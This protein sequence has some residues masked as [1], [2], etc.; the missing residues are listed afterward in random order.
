MV[1]IN[2]P[3]VPLPLTA[4]VELRDLQS[5]AAG[6][7]AMALL[8]SPK[9]V[10]D[11]AVASLIAPLRQSNARGLCQ[12]LEAWDGLIQSNPRTVEDLG[13]TMMIVVYNLLDLC[14][15]L[16]EQVSR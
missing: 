3:V 14:R 5:K 10:S 8:T 1:L 15:L 7:V 9:L 11:P 16:L 2:C 6:Q 12:L 13:S 4:P